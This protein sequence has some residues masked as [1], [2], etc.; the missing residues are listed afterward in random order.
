MTALALAG[1][2][3][4]TALGSGPQ[5]FWDG[6]RRGARAFGPLTAF[7][8]EFRSR[9][10]AAVRPAD[11]RAAP[12]HRKERLALTAAR[13]ALRAAG[14][15]RLPEGALVVIVSQALE[16]STGTHAPH[17]PVPGRDF[18][19]PDPDALLAACGSTPGAAAV[20]H[21]S[22]ACASAAFGA[23]FARE[24]LLSGLGT[25][26]L[27]VGASAL[28][29]YEYDSM[30][31]VRTL[32]PA[33]ARPFDTRRDG[34]TVGEGG[35]ALVLETRQSALDRGHRPQA[36]LSGAACLV[37]STRAVAS[38]P[39]AIRDCM[40]AALEDAGVG[41]VDYV[42]AHATGTSQGDAAEVAAVGEVSRA[43]GWGAVPVS[44]HKG[45]VGHLLHASAFP[46]VVAATC[47]LREA[48]LPGTPGLRS[49]MEVPDGVRPVITAVPAPRAQHALVNSFGFSGNNAALVVSAVGR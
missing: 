36:L 23:V 47:F 6:L 32:S 48:W 1:T 42:H 40:L 19:G 21:L 29:P 14:L 20:V 13:Q 33:G 3:L 35:G 18:A 28:N 43:L 24:W 10:V 17:A 15:H 9:T 8:G 2:G 22:H 44:S 37:D 25:T 34:L 38:E 4:V 46:G 27:V 16:L 30:D 7:E 49:L 39:A 31:V 41:R 26:A 11:C 5:A 12:G 45:A